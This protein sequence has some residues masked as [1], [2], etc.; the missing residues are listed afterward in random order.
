MPRAG[1]PRA[2]LL[3]GNR[4]DRGPGTGPDTPPTALTRATDTPKNTKRGMEKPEKH[5]KQ[6]NFDEL[7]QKEGGF[8]TKIAQKP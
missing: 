7:S 5:R 6:P 3:A 4:E 8:T 2:F 1:T